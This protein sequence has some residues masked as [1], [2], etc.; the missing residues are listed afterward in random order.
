M[1]ALVKLKA[2]QQEQNLRGE[3]YGLPAL[4]SL[5]LEAAEED[6]PRSMPEVSSSMTLS[7]V[8]LPCCLR[9][10]YL[11]CSYVGYMLSEIVPP[12]A[13]SG[14]DGGAGAPKRK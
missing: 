13:M 11:F 4:T 5:E 12:R 9:G 1:L 6:P 10:A 7:N 8:S 2:V 14:T 3:E